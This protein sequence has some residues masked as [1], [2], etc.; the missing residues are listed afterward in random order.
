MIANVSKKGLGVN[1]IKEIN[2]ILL[3]KSSEPKVLITIHCSLSS[4]NNDLNHILNYYDN[5]NVNII[6]TNY[7][8]VVSIFKKK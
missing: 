5:Y 2:K 7:K 3:R 6:E 8:V 4:Y 1:L